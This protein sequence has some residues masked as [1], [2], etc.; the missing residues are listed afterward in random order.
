M[1]G[2]FTSSEPARRRRTDYHDAVDGEVQVTVVVIGNNGAGRLERCLSALAATADVAFET[3]VVGADPA[4][5]GGECSAAA[6]RAIAGSRGAYLAFL[7]GHALVEPRWLRSLVDALASDASIGAA[8]STLHWRDQPELLCADGGRLTW[9][10]IAFDG[11]Q[12][13]LAPDPGAAP[14]R[15]ETSFPT[16]AAMLIGRRDWEAA[17]GFDPAFRAGN[18]DADLGWRLWLAGRRVV[19]CS[20]SVVRSEGSQVDAGE[21]PHGWVGAARLRQTIRMLL[22][23]YP[24]RFLLHA[25]HWSV[26]ARVA[27]GAW[28]SLVLALAWNLAHLP[29][30]LLRR[31]RIQ[32]TRRT[33]HEE[34][35]ARGVLLELAE[36]PRPPTVASAGAISDAAEWIPSAVLLPGADSALGRLGAGWFPAAVRGGVQV[37]AVAATARCS[38]R[39]ASAASGVLQAH[40]RLPE[41][42]ADGDAVT[43]SCNGASA[44]CPGPG[45]EWRR[46]DL[47]V[48]ARH[49]GL[50]E[51]E[52]RTPAWQSAAGATVRELRFVPDDPRPSEPP[53]TIS[54]IIPTFNRWAILA[55]TL[56]AL[57]SQTMRE[58]EVI[59]VDDGSSDGTWD[60]LAAWRRSHP[61]VPLKA[62][63]QPNLKPGRARNRGL[64]DATGDLVLF[65]GDDII[66]QPDF[67]AQHLAKHQEVG[68][69]IGVLGLTEWDRARMNVTPFLEF[70]NGDG[71]QFAY[72]HFRDGGDIFFT[73]FYTS[74][75]SLPR[76]VLGTDPFHPAFTFVDW[77]DV[78]LGY[79]LSLRGLRLIYHAG[80][81]AAHYHPTS[82]RQFYRRQ[83]HVGRTIGVILGL[84]PELATSPA[85]PP[86]EPA[87][88]FGWAR[89]VAPALIP[90]L[91]LWD[92]RGGRCPLWLYR[93]LLLC[94][95]WTGR[96]QGLTATGP[97]GTGG[98]ASGT[99]Q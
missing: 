50:L 11:S 53:A 7:A 99:V 98:A 21:R 43:V 64:R 97:A 86:L 59:V 49:D 27:S 38:L 88:W 4:R 8:C 91:E 23:H 17:G 80:A 28:R 45:G 2:F 30:T 10:G 52:L 66:P 13:C 94:A 90:L 77:E 55:E 95:F 63:R 47:P 71:P 69:D 32:R 60:S 6:S 72:S 26:R 79:R 44:A 57:G 83:K 89:R 3:V 46:V 61:E 82:I 20:D 19:V 65:L 70:V 5:R 29:A 51:V 37:R 68:E 85:M 76:R 33:A 54:V 78:E 96:L 35:F 93:N 81:R 36:P 84:H 48:Q 41:Q 31:R 87:P 73:G 12:S 25:L 92:R 56:A 1:K 22:K 67:L 39:V 40:L 42:A 18:A 62:V 9:L 24:P 74:N 16:I 75:I 14:T 15:R 34:L 58:F